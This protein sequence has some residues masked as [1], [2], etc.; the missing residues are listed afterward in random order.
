MDSALGDPFA[1]AHFYIYDAFFWISHKGE[2][3]DIDFSD[4]S[5]TV[6]HVFIK[7]YYAGAK[8]V[9][10][11]FSALDL[12]SSE[13]RKIFA[14][15]GTLDDND[16]SKQESVGSVMSEIRKRDRSGRSSVECEVYTRMR[17]V[18]SHHPSILIRLTLH[19]P[20]LGN[21][22]TLPDM[23][24]TEFFHNQVELYELAQRWMMPGLQLAAIQT[25]KTSLFSMRLS[26]EHIQ[27]LFPAFRLVF[28]VTRETDSGGR[29]NGMR[30][31]VVWYTAA[32]Y[33]YVAK[34]D[35]FNAVMGE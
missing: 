19:Q 17:N 9:D 25:F 12:L 11:L 20:A 22:T 21:I 2:P 28:E 10:P 29:P 31:L 35:S 5:S 14:A 18:L 30:Q 33:R 32:V 26:T 15:E 27:H 34:S 3:R 8:E 6:F 23:D 4:V 1:P 13:N 16:T 7:V 24:L